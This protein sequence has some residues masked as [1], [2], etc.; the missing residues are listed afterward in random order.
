MTYP[1][2]I[3]EFRNALLAYDPPAEAA[4]AIHDAQA[5]ASGQGYAVLSVSGASG[6]ALP[7]LKGRGRFPLLLFTQELLALLQSGI[8]LVE[9]IETLEEKESRPETRATLK[10]LLTALYEGKSRSDLNRLTRVHMTARE[11]RRSWPAWLRATA[12]GFPFG[13][14]P[15]GGS[16]IPTF[17]SYATERKLSPHKDEFGTT[18]AIEGVAGPEAANNAA[19]RVDEFGFMGL[20]GEE[21]QSSQLTRTTG[22]ILKL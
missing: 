21:G 2:T 5:Q 3:Q 15:A 9:A 14:I 6:F 7:S 10:R 17:L 20:G 8:S 22:R 16:E 11:W 1:Q 19:I 13:T 18:G 12:I 4:D